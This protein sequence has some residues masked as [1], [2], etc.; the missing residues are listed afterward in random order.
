M[1]FPRVLVISNN[2]FSKSCS[3]GRTLGNLFIGW[4]KDKI[5][6]FCIST[7]EPD[8]D[9]CENYYLLTDRSMLTS[10]T[11]LAKGARCSMESNYGTA[12][13]TI[14]GGKKVFKT[15]FKALL[16]CLVWSNKRWNSREFKQWVGIFNPEVV[17]VMNSDA[18]FIL[19]LARYISRQRK[20]PLV[21]YNTE[22][23]Y[24][25]K[26]NYLNPS[27]FFNNTFFSVYQYIYRLHFKAMMK[28]VSL[29]FHLNPLL[30]DDYSRE[31]NGEHEVLYGASVLHFDKGD[32]HT[33][34]PVFTYLGNFG[35]DRPSA[36]IEVA[37]VLQSINPNY[38]LDVYGKI[39]RPEIRE[40]FDNCPG[41]NYKGVIPYDEVVNVIYN[42]TILFHVES[43]ASQYEESLRYGFSTKIADS[44]CSGHPFLMYSSKNIAGARYIIDTGSG[45][46]ASDR[47]ELRGEIIEI[48]YN[49]N[50]RNKV[51]DKAQF[52]ASE[53]HSI[54][55]NTNIIREKLFSLACENKR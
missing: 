2:S 37:E 30:R 21:M 24:F 32:L 4:P 7:A 43:Q 1:E 26:H 45:W 13:N 34:A 20:I 17:L 38:R 15:P 39:P 8:Y 52:V 41:L 51:L 33:E 42:S 50:A 25:F 44:I 3:N 54:K 28:N 19:D 46:Q 16:R 53:N 40:R 6:Q 14:V 11:H 31:F 55:K 49:E 9:V 35:F 23:F 36:L 18:T 22:G 27:R 10:L 12:G 29:S 5:A 47:N 48:L